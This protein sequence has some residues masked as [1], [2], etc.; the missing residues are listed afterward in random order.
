[1]KR[2]IHHLISADELIVAIGLAWG[3]LN[4]RQFEQADRL[5]KGCLQVWPNDTN[6]LVMAAYVSV[7]LSRS[8]DSATIEMLKNAECREWADFVLRR[9]DQKIIPRQ[10]PL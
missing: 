7:E 9:A 4:V 3:H 2:N 10:A 6:L 5:L 8:L 1:M